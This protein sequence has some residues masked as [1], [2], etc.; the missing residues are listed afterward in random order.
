MLYGFLIHAYLQALH[1]PTRSALV[2]MCFVHQAFTLL[3]S[4]TIFAY[5][6]SVPSNRTLQY[7]A[8]VHFGSKGPDRRRHL[9]DKILLGLK[10]IFPPLS[11]SKITST[12]LVDQSN[13]K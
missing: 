6:L 7:S 1:Q 3:P 5:V 12:G 9:S 8:E 10:N 13:K 2:T 4:S 11:Y